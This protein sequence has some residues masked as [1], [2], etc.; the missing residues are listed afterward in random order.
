MVTDHVQDLETKIYSEPQVNLVQAT[1]SKSGEAGFAETIPMMEGFEPLLQDT[2]E[3][4]VKPFTTTELDNIKTEEKHAFEIK[5]T[6][7]AV[8]AEDF[9]PKEATGQTPKSTKIEDKKAKVIKKPTKHGVSALF[10][11][12]A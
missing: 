1:E 2:E 5:S 11:S 4:N 12:F 7:V 10:I 9:K 6:E 3:V 8:A